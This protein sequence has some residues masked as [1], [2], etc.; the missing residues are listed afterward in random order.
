MNTSTIDRYTLK[1]YTRLIISFFGSLLVLTVYQYA[2]LYFKGVV[3]VIFGTS[4]FIALVHQMGYSSLVGVLL[5]FPFNFW[6][7]LRP[8]YGFNLVFVVLLLLLMIEAMLISYFCTALVPLGSDLLGYSFEDIQTTI[9]NSGGISWVLPLG[10][11]GIV[12]MFFGLYKVSSKHYHHINKMYPFTIILI[13]MFIATL[14]IEGKP[15][16]HNKTQYLALNLYDSSTEDTSYNS[17]VE[18]PLI[19]SKPIPNV[20]GEYFQLKDSKPNIVFIMVEGLGRDFVG[21]GAEYGGFTPFLDS[22]TTKSLYWENCL[23]NTGRT[24]GVLP[25]LLGSLPF[26]KSG[27]MELEKY[28]NKLTLFSILK[29]NGYHTSFYQGT[30]SSFDNV[31][32]FLSSENVDFVLDKSGFGKNYQMQAEDAAGAS[33]GYPD[34]ELFKKSM[35]LPREAEQPR[36]EVYMTIS[37]HEPFI[38]PKK[39]FYEAKVAQL[40]SKRDYDRKT[41]KVIEKNDNVFAT[42]LYADDALKYVLEAYRQQPN[43]D[44]TI[45]IITGD[46]RLI[47]IPQRNNLSRF[48]VPLIM[49]SPLL[50]QTK[51]ISAVNSHFDVTPTLLALLEANYE[52]KMPKKVAWMGDALDM[53]EEFRSKKHIPLMRNKNELKEFVDGEKLYSDGSVYEL[54]ENMD[55]SSAF[56]GSKSEAK[57]KAFKSMN[58]YVTNKDKIIPDSLAIFSVKKEKFTDSEIIWI[59]SVY[60]GQNFDKVYMIARELA[61]E[62]EYEKSLLLSRY[63]LSEAPS[64]IDTKI[65]TGRVNVWMGNYDKSIEILKDCI[66]MNPNYIDSYSALFDVYFW[67]ERPKE[68]IELIDQVERNSSSA[69]EIKDKIERAR[70]QAQK[71][72]I[73]ASLKKKNRSDT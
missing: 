20:L 46:H 10:F 2:T 4:F 70:R 36:M 38:P 15:I 27:F 44:N 11:I 1:H 40:L 53:S 12:G 37:T 56:G 51:K 6:E 71:K 48:H 47:P 73:A 64:H 32:R 57:L 17:D 62:R 34:K 16:D 29:N 50:K 45:F 25:S 68:A 14:F 65:L 58:A 72:G 23:S 28:P 7:N 22:L 3:D 67:S 42:L 43:Y 59:N 69:H 39:D 60:N 52:L 9:A 8:R 30:N 21:E 55:L 61:F 13:S 66:K 5:A 26:G 24:F 31:D 54:D 63:I 33:W 41:K 18:Y 19:K 35:S 49:F